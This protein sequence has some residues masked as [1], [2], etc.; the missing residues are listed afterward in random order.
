MEGPL[1]GHLCASVTLTDPS[2]PL[3][4]CVVLQRRKSVDV[5]VLPQG[6]LPKLAGGLPE[7]SQVT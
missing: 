2:L 7:D 5:P 4:S 3:L 1:S 6:S